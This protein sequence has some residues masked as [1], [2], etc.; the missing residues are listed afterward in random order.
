MRAL[1]CGSM[2]VL[3]LVTIAVAGC[4]HRN[5]SDQSN[6]R[7]TAQLM[8]EKGSA[9]QKILL[10]IINT[11]HET[12]SIV[13]DPVGTLVADVRFHPADGSVA[14][15][16]SASSL[17]GVPDDPYEAGYSDHVVRILTPGETFQTIDP[18][19]W[20]MLHVVDNKVTIRPG[21]Y[22]L[23]VHYKS[24]SREKIAPSARA[25]WKSPSWDLISFPPITLEIKD[26][27][28]AQP[29]RGRG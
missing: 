7:T 3:C 20:H 28:S 4:I 1:R 13:T 26:N 19:A 16:W 22:E 15:E 8:G 29:S 23:T 14:H 17:T 18:V 9:D 5:A 12:F 2:F 11:T 6:P 25:L 21:R 27:A 10:R 24:P